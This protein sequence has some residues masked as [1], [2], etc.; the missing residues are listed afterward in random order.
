MG[1]QGIAGHGRVS[2]SLEGINQNFHAFTRDIGQTGSIFIDPQF[3]KSIDVTRGGSSGTGALGSLGSSVDFKY[4]DLEDILRP[5]KDFGGMVRGSTGFSKYSNGQQPSGSFFLGGRNERWEAMVGASHSKNDFYKIGDNIS[6]DE[7]MHGIHGRNLWFYHG[8]DSSIHDINQHGPC[9]YHAHGY[10]GMSNCGLTTDQAKW[11]KQAAKNPLK[12]TQKETDS[13]MLRLRHYFNDDHDQSLE[14]FVFSSKAKYE[15][16]QQPSIWVP[17]N[18]NSTKDNWWVDGEASWHDYPWSVRTQLRN[19]V[20]SLKWKGSFSEIFNPE[21][22]IFHERQDRKQNWT[23]ASDGFSA[24]QPLHYFTD[25]GST[26]IKLSNTSRLESEVIGPF[27]LD[28]G[29][30]FRQAR[31]K[32]DSETESEYYERYLLETQ[33]RDVDIMRFD[34]DSRTDTLGLALSLSTEGPGP[35]QASAGIG[36]QRVWLDVLNPVFTEGNIGQEGVVYGT[37]YW[38]KYYRGLGYSGNELKELAAAATAESGAKIKT[39]PQYGN[40]RTVRGRRDHQWNL[41]SANVGVS[42]SPP[43]TG[44][45]FYTQA[46]YSERAPTSN[47]MYMHGELNRADFY[48]NPYLE[49]EENLSLQLGMNYKKEGWIAT[50]DRLDVGVNFYRNRIRNYITWGPMVAEGYPWPGIGNDQASVNN[51][52]PFVRQGVELNLAYRQPLFYVRTNLTLPIRHDNKLCSWQ[53]PSGRAYQTGT[54]SD[55]G[56]SYTDIGKGKRLCYSSWNWM[57]AGTIE[58]IR[59]SLTAALTPMQGRLELGGTMHYRG[60]QRAAYWYD[61]DV[62]NDYHLGTQAGQTQPIPSQSQFIE[63]Y[64]W[65]KV[66][67]FDLF[68]NYQFNDQ[69]RAGIYLANVTNKMEA[70][71][72]TWGYNFYPGRTLTANLE[73][74]F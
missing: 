51:L 7:L 17:V 31:K 3:L 23:G 8:A 50:S 1:V 37:S 30:E 9:R 29:L 16:D 12:G 15:T 22:Q 52:N 13:Q 27:R 67:K 18:E 56:N 59:G 66:I 35:W 41:K 33:G 26:G 58:P 48:A 65:P 73:Y 68:V 42:Y 70:T 34:P 69:L 71:P 49:P 72:T 24:N 28:A 11:L 46:G 14:L 40:L 25:V 39:D 44:L 2:Q 43:G 21:V 19:Q 53:V 61:R 38:R 5:G 55:G 36:F 64:L 10:V 47:E 32:V 74:R 63:T 20:A 62:Q 45:T 54:T 6:N 57:E 4:L 60:R